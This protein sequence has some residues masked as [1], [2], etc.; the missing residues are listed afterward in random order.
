MSEDDAGGLSAA[1]DTA[2]Y[3]YRKSA[4]HVFQ[5]E[6]EQA[7]TCAAPA[8]TLLGP[9]GVLRISCADP[10]HDPLQVVIDRAPAHGSITSIAT[11][12]D[13]VA[14]IMYVESPGGATHDSFTFHA[15]DGFH[16]SAVGTDA[17]DLMPSLAAQT[18]LVKTTGTQRSRVSVRFGTSSIVRLRRHAVTVA[19]RCAQRAC[20]GTVELRRGRTLLAHARFAVA[21]GGAVR[22]VLHLPHAFR[23]RAR[24]RLPV[25]L[26]VRASAPGHDPATFQRI[27][28]LATGPGAR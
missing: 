23:V 19:F 2:V 10:N 4:L 5:R 18:P 26:R 12:V 13:G 9:V 22:V 16:T 8:S 21:K 7:P 28:Y 27:L 25:T 3:Y 14:T 24:R 1:T 11:G 20:R 15:D 6:T 17:F